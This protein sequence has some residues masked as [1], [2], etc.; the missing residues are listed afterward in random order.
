MKPTNII[1][2][3]SAT[4]DSGTVSWGAIRDYHKNKGWSDIGYHFG[5]EL[6]GDEYEI[7]AGRMADK[8][9]AHCRAGGM[10]NRSIG[11]CCVGDYDN[12]NPP[13]EMIKKCLVLTRYLMRT[14]GIKSDRV[15]GHR[16]LEPAKTCP[17]AKFDME[18]FRA[19]LREDWVDSHV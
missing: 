8:Q 7:L 9:G 12:E 2:H 16:E 19:M 18:L 5:V 10:N 17:G 15:L 6:V 14:Y 1:I 11:V 3:C 4:K 13:E